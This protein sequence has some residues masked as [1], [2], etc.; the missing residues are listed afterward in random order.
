MSTNFLAGAVAAFALLAASQSPA[1]AQ[2]P[3]PVAKVAYASGEARTP[4]GWIGFCQRDPGECAVDPNE[5]EVVALTPQVWRQ[6]QAV[7]AKVNK[8]IKPITDM[9]HWGVVEQWDLPTDGMGDCEDYVLLK[10]HK[11][12][13]AGLSRRAMRVTVVLDEVGEGHAVLMLRTDRGDLILDNKRDA[14]LSWH[15]TGYTYIKRESQDR[16]GWTS[17]GGATSP[18][19]TAAR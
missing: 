1:L 4:I 2:P 3:L 19:V 18:T 8:D 7:N 14:L 15:E 13:L 10:R 11:L 16:I 9:D 12:A 17:L 5:P 6:I